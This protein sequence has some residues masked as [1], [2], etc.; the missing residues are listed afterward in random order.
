MTNSTT[1]R[2]G[3]RNRFVRLWKGQ[4]YQSRL[5]LQAAEFPTTIAKPAR[6]AAPAT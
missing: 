6:P 5:D 1:R 3:P 4:H 2:P